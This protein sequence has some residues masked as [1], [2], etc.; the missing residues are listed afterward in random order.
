VFAGLDDD[1]LLAEDEQYELGPDGNCCDSQGNVWVAHYGSGKVVGFDSDGRLLTK[2]RLP[3]GRR[4]TNVA[5][6]PD[7]R[8]LYVTES[9]AGLLY[10]AAFDDL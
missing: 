3:Q 8:M 5:M 4:P 10:R 9:E 2:I 6:T 1:C 7:S